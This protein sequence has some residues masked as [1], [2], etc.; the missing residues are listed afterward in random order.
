MQNTIYATYASPERADQVFVQ[1]LE[2]GASLLD[3]VVITTQ[4]YQGRFSEPDD[5]PLTVQEIAE[6]EK[7]AFDIDQSARE[8]ADAAQTPPGIDML[9][10]DPAQYAKQAYGWD[11]FEQTDNG[12]CL[13]DQLSMPGDLASCLR[14]LGFSDLTARQMETVVLNGGAILILRV[15][16]GSVTEL[17]GVAL[18]QQGDAELRSPTES[19][20]YLI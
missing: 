12:V 13:L 11:P 3:I 9:A 5:R 14:N 17:Q 2:C 1:L 18:I 8:S 7:I 20:P 16:S 10:L 19:N 4:N 15:P 6:T